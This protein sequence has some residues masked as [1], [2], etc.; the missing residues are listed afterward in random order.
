ML[1]FYDIR[2]SLV[3]ISGSAAVSVSLYRVCDD[4]FCTVTS[5]GRRWSIQTL[6]S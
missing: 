5:D 3:L 4:A 6:D 2:V 1:S